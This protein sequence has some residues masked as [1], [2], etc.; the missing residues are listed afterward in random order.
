[1]ADGTVGLSAKVGLLV[2]SRRSHKGQHNGIVPDLVREF[3]QFL[4]GRRDTGYVWL[5]WAHVCFPIHCSHCNGK[6]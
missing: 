2:L 3:T 5:S 6:V 4:E 1:M